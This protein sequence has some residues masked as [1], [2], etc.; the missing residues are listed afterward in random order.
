VTAGTISRRGMGD[1]PDGAC[2]FTAASLGDGPADL[3]I[4][5]PGRAG[6]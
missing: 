4:R 5:P 2:L 1:P 3:V 6:W